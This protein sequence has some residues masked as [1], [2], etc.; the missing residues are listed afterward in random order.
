MFKKKKKK[1]QKI[2]ISPINETDF[3]GS[4]HFYTENGGKTPVDFHTPD[5]VAQFDIEE[6]CQAFISHCD[7][8]HYNGDFMDRLID[9]KI[10]AGKEDLK[11]QHRKHLRTIYNLENN[12]NCDLVVIS[13]NLNILAEAKSKL[14]KQLSYLGEETI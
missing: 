2:K 3:S 14:E 12:I 13:Q 1:S 4:I 10:E 6:E 8:D 9:E 5:V 11:H 7:L